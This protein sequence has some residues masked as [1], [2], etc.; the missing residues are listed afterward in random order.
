MRSSTVGKG[1]TLDCPVFCCWEHTVG[2]SPDPLTNADSLAP[3][4]LRSP[5]DAAVITVK[6]VWMS[7]KMWGCFYLPAAS[8]HRSARILLQEGH[9][10]HTQVLQAQWKSH[11][12]P[13]KMHVEV[14]EPGPDVD[15]NFTCVTVSPQS[16]SLMFLKPFLSHA[17]K[18]P[19]SLRRNCRLQWKCAKVE[20]PLLLHHGMVCGVNIEAVTDYQSNICWGKSVA[21]TK[22]CEKTRLTVSCVSCPYV[23][24]S[25]LA[26]SG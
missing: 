24:I 10:K 7:L 23:I 19:G 16:T 26:Q 22:H 11:Q 5:S 6:M 9:H 8:P 13:A 2:L 21:E 12:W 4:S 18:P 15:H 1:Q 17:K 20:S 3:V 25:S 14:H